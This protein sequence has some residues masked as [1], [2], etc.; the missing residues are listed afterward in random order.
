MSEKMKQYINDTAVK[1][2]RTMAQA[3]VGVIGSTALINEVNWF[4]VGSTVALSGV[5]C[6][7]MS[8]SNLPGKEEAEE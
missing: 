6:I 5:M 4:V 7:L 3:A 8:L 2:V 1:T